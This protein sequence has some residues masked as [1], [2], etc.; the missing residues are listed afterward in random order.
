MND[1][2]EKWRNKN[3]PTDVLSFGV[4]DEEA[5]ISPGSYLELGDI[6]VSVDAAERQAQEH[7]HSLVRELRWLVSHGF[8]HLLGYDHI[9]SND[10]QR[11]EKLEILI[12]DK[13]GYNNPYQ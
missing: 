7:N 3:E 11:M 5:L 1:H 4:L 9:N 8:L 10:Q 12:L 13:L 6:V 2:N